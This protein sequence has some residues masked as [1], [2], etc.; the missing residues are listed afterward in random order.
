MSISTK[1]WVSFIELYCIVLII[2]PE[3]ASVNSI[4]EKPVAALA[5]ATLLKVNCF[6]SKNPT[7]AFA[8]NSGKTNDQTICFLPAASCTELAV[9]A[10]SKSVWFVI[11]E[12]QGTYLKVLATLVSLLNISY[13]LHALTIAA[14]VSVVPP[15]AA[16]LVPV[17]ADVVV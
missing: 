5:S 3:D 14:D 13:W 16:L 2:C 7:S 10:L 11:E 12:L 15:V 17:V 8:L 4:S 9:K 6:I 1:V